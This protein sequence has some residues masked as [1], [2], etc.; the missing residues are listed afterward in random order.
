MNTQD[1][2]YQQK[3]KSISSAKPNYFVHLA[4]RYP[5]LPALCAHCMQGPRCFIFLLLIP[6][7]PI[8]LK[9]AN[10]V[11]KHWCLIG[12]PQICCNEN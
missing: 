10:P 6:L 4:I 2:K 7:C 8:R 5:V 1:L 3:S 11:S 9:N 12:K